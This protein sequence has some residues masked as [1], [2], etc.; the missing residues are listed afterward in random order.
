MQRILTAPIVILVPQTVTAFLDREVVVDT[1]KVEINFQS[2]GGRE[3]N[4]SD[5][6]P[7]RLFRTDP[8]GGK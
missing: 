4:A 8:K 7:S 6:D 2:S 5:N 3:E 1:D